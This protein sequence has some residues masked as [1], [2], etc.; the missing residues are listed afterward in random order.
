MLRNSFAH[1]SA[2]C[3]PDVLR[4]QLHAGEPS[5]EPT[6][7]R[8]WPEVEDEGRCRSIWARVGEQQWRGRR[9]SIFA[10]GV[11]ATEALQKCQNARK[12]PE[13]KGFSAFS[14]DP[15]LTTPG[16][17]NYLSKLDSKRS[18]TMNWAG[19]N[20]ADI[21]AAQPQAGEQARVPGPDEDG[22]RSQDAQPP[23]QARPFA[24]GRSDRRQVGSAGRVRAEAFPR[25]ARIRLGSEIRALLERGKRERTKHL[26]VFFA[27]SPVLFSR[28]GVIVPKHGHEI[29]ERNRV[30]RRLREIGR[31]R[32]LR[33]LDAEAGPTDLLLRARPG[34]YGVKHSV[35]EEELMTAV[36]AWCCRRL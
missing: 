1:R 4:A 14:T 25:S 9:P 16:A 17:Q 22:R 19:R 21:Q 32:G 8:R 6:S 30:K 28:L 5:P 23:S 18:A 15:P 26:D 35:L 24:A 13:S 20:E 34:A 31:R 10:R 3:G 27:A 36:E 11:E 33:V 7:R 2:H 29:V 12:G